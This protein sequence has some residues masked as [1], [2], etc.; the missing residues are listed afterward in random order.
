MVS[1]FLK[2]AHIILIN[3]RFYNN[4][5]SRGKKM[6]YY[7]RFLL[8]ITFLLSSLVL[9]QLP[10]P[11]GHWT[12]DEGSDYITADVSGNGNDGVLWSDGVFWSD[13]TPTG[14][15]YSLEFT[16]KTGAVHIGDPDTLKIVGEIT[17][18]AWVKTGPATENWQNIIAKGHGDNAEI[19]LRLD[20]NGHPSQIWCGSYKDA[21]HMV[22]SED[23]TDDQLNTWVHVVGTYSNEWQVWTLY[24]N[25]EWVA[26]TPDVVGAVTVVDLGR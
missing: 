21:D 14:H 20:G 24:F 7:I 9:A 11:V 26:E 25:G 19:V 10:D 5:I 6:K 2:W 17:L 23:L 3:F 1:T 22:K 12:F 18:A 16:G 15:G 8:C 13:D 4:L